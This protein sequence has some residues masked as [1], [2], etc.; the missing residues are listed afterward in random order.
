MPKTQLREEMYI[1]RFNCD[2]KEIMIR[3]A[4]CARSVTRLER[5]K[6]SVGTMVRLFIVHIYSLDGDDK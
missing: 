2:A 3:L 1:V 4:E 6:M 5:Q